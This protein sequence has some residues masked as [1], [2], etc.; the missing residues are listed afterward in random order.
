M[1]YFKFSEYSW[2]G[3]WVVLLTASLLVTMH[4]LRCI[5]R[6][7]DRRRSSPRQDGIA[8]IVEKEDAEIE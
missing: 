8:V 6:V 3:W 1:K 7:L 5:S 4:L 2:P